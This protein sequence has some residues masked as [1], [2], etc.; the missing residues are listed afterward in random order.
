MLGRAQLDGVRGGDTK[1]LSEHDRDSHAEVARGAGGY[2][3]FCL[4]LGLHPG[5][6]RKSRE[7]NTGKFHE[8]IWE[9]EFESMCIVC[10]WMSSSPLGGR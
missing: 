9:Y 10:V 3:D 1:V 6:S 2:H 7:H 8:Q 4:Y 5:I